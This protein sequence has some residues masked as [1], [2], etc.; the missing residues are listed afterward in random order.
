MQIDFS[1]L[2]LSHGNG[3]QFNKSILS[4]TDRLIRVQSVG[5]HNINTLKTVKKSVL[6]SHSASE[7]HYSLKGY[8]VYQ[9][10][11][12]TFVKVESGSWLLI[13]A[14]YPH[15]IV[16]HSEPYIKLSCSFVMNE[17]KKDS[18]LKT[19]LAINEIIKKGEFLRG[20]ISETSEL[21]IT[22]LYSKMFFTSPLQRNI[23]E[24]IANTIIL[25]TLSVLCTNTQSTQKKDK[26]RY[27]IA[28]QFI[29]DNLRYKLSCSDVAKKVYLSPRQIDRIF[30]KNASMS[31]TEFIFVRKCEKATELLS[32]TD[33]PLRMISEQLGFSDYAYFSRF[34]KQRTGISPNKFRALHQSKK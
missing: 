34:F 22:Q 8:A 17:D 26:D 29:E 20:K 25:D 32:T 23:I 18:D 27:A 12:N 7:L 33:V 6:H 21:S 28:I 14:N 9:C 16:K 10:P 19:Y 11:D 13:P 24:S 1:E 31:V 30:Q 3:K 4:D 15:R 2:F 5:L